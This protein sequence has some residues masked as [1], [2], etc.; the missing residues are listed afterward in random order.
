[1]IIHNRILSRTLTTE[2]Y[3]ANAMFFLVVMGFCFGFMRGAEHMALAGYFVSSPWLVLIPISVWVVYSLKVVSYN[4]DEV[5]TERNEFLYSIPLLPFNEKI[6][7]CLTVCS[8]QLAPALAYGSFLFLIALKSL[9]VIECALILIALV[10]LT[11]I[12]THQ[13]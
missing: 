7:A 1:M 4:R 3:R 6:V 13:L 5:N 9:H 2:F 11:A 12:T 10:S 8:G